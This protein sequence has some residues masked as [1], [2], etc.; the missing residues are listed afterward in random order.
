MWPEHPRIFQ[1]N[2]WTWLHDLSEHYGRRITL[3]DVPDH[4]LDVVYSELAGFDA[5]W[6]MG[7]WQRSPAG[8]R[9]A[10]EHP[11]LQAEYAQA[12]P[13]WGA[14]D[15]VGSPYSIAAYEV[16]PHLGG[17]AGL[18]ALRAGLARRG[19]RLLLDY[20]PNHTALDHVWLREHPDAYIQATPEARA[21]HPDWFFGYDAHYIAHGR[22]PYFP[23]WTDTA[24]IN[25]FAPDARQV[26]RDALLRIADMCDG[27]RC[28]MA[29][30]MTTEVF[31]GTWG[32]LA[33]PAPDREF[34][35]EIIATVRAANPDFIFMAEVYWEME[36]ALQQ[37]GFDY[38]YDKRLYDRL[39]EDTAEAVR[40]HLIADTSYQN[41][42]VRFT[43]NHDEP[44]AASAFKMR[45]NIAANVLCATL[46]GAHLMHEGQPRGHRVKLPVQLG[47][48]P[49]EKDDPRLLALYERLLARLPRREGDWRLLYV[50]A[51]DGAEHPTLIAYA[52]L[53]PLWLVVVNYS[54]HGAGGFVE[55]PHTAPAFDDL[56]TGE[57]L[58]V[59]GEAL[60]VNLPP[61]GWYLLAPQTD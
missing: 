25:A 8:R 24:Q 36:Y 32:D 17:M 21:A 20:V 55:I 30:L 54:D 38:C 14:D 42:L 50:A 43:E 57:R 61:W 46:P 41:K 27:V 52:W 33:G 6:L 53:D 16:D 58:H 48:R 22:D 44:R 29:M 37:Q 31:A 2:T 11:D 13:D 35:P 12:L 18:A 26:S 47:R 49:H 5:V 19:L 34:W 10:Y 7:V 23:P 28:D 39:V 56:L 4:A 15:V 59:G 60:A 9:I 3:A 1:L 40:T 45:Q 51:P